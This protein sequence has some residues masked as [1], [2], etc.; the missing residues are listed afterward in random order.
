MS[1]LYFGY[2][3]NLNLSDLRDYEKRYFHTTRFVDSLKILDGI[4]FLPDY[5]L[6]FPVYST[7]RNGGVLNAYPNFG[8]VVSGKLFQITD[9][10]L[11]DRKEGS[12]NFYQKI[13]IKVISEKGELKEAFTYVVL[14]TKPNDYVKPNPKYV[15]VV[16]HGMDDF[17]I[18]SKYQWLQENLLNASENKQTKFLDQVFVYGTLLEGECREKPMN[19]ISSSKSK[20]KILGKMYDIG[21]YPAITNGDNEIHGELHMAN[22]PKS[23]MTLDCIEGFHGYG[24]SSLYHR[25]VVTCDGKLCWTYFWN[26]SVEN[27]SEIESG[28][29]K[30]RHTN[31]FENL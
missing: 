6:N 31:K 11:L 10:S 22:D 26:N 20:T 7:S 24:D 18:S 1:Q 30:N 2:G 27:L 16:S 3:S 25:K 12:P 8:H 4:Y 19:D 5:E 15:E 13:P 17:H 14:N 28:N 9:S 29:W 21:S 23:I